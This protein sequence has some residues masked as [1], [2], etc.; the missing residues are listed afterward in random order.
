MTQKQQPPNQ[1]CRVVGIGFLGKAV[2]LF[3]LYVY[4]TVASKYQPLDIYWILAELVSWRLRSDSQ[5]HSYKEHYVIHA[6]SC[7]LELQCSK[8]KNDGVAACINQPHSSSFYY[9]CLSV[10]IRRGILA[11]FRTV[12]SQQKTLQP[13]IKI[14]PPF[15]MNNQKYQ[16][17]AETTLGLDKSII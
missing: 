2:S 14:L 8:S 12:P 6:T 4:Y 9:W 10:K 5:R 1:Y 11:L 17:K 15:K 3:V 13:N 16:R 7:N